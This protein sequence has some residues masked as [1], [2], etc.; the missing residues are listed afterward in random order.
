[1]MN[2]P[3]E[4]RLSSGAGTPA[5]T[6]IARYEQTISE[7]VETTLAGAIQETEAPTHVAERVAGPWRDLLTVIAAEEL[8]HRLARAAANNVSARLATGTLRRTLAPYGHL[9]VAA[10]ETE[11]SRERDTSHAA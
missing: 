3:Q 1:M 4:R 7:V 2:N 8:S 9:I 10:I 5:L 6:L 11:L